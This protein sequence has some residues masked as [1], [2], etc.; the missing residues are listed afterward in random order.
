M[1]DAVAAVWVPVED[2]ERAVAF[3]RDVLRLE[4]DDHDSD[5]SSV[6]AGGLMIGLNAREETHIVDGGAVISFTP[7]GTIDDEVTRLK[8][9]GVHFTG[10]ISEHPWGR[11]V[12]FK[13]SE[14]N[15]LQLY[16][17]PSS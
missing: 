5:W 7:E 14:G 6:R 9:A 17:P 11:I 8:G 13:D 4:L 3:Y 2:M 1:A 16:T 12:P 10:E 15:D